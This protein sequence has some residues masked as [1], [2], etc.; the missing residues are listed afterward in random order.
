MRLALVLCHPSNNLDGSQKEV[1]FLSEF[2]NLG[3]TAKIFRAHG[4]YGKPTQ[5]SFGQSFDAEFF[6]PDD[7]K[8]KPLHT[9]SSALVQNVIAFRPAVIILKGMGYSINQSIRE[10][11]PDVP[12]GFIVG[13]GL[14]DPLK[15]TASFVFCEYEEQAELH[16]PSLQDAGRVIILPK[17]VNPN[18]ISRPSSIVRDIDM[19]NSGSYTDPRKNHKA[20]LD[21]LDGRQC[22]LAGWGKMDETLKTRLETAGARLVGKLSHPDLY[23]LFWRSKIMVHPSLHDGLPRSVVEAMACGVIPVCL[24]ATIYGGLT[25]GVHGFLADDVPSMK[26]YVDLLLSDSVLRAK[27]SSA[28]RVHAL[29]RHGLKAIRLSARKTE[30]LLLQIA[31]QGPIER[32]V[33]L[34]RRPWLRLHRQ[35]I[36][37]V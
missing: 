17:Y 18:L 12:F 11:L 14:R 37:Q 29:K 28:A 7:L 25:H 27:M 10:A 22:A 3:H 21:I 1:E 9:L 26:T 5:Q 24:R 32:M 6:A 33:R 19:V 4:P 23:A 13:G 35:P 20:L 36:P 8:T 30:P 16:F 34:A 31:N 15:D 2:R